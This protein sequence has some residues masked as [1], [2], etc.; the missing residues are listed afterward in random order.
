MVTRLQAEL[1]TASITAA[2]G[3]AVMVGATEFGIG[4]VK[5]GP[6]PGTFP[7][8]MGLLV[9][10]ASIGTAI[11]TVL[12]PVL[13][14][15]TFLD[16]RQL[17][18]VAAFVLPMVAF[19]VAAKLLGLYVATALYLFGSMLVQGGYG[20]W[21]SAAVALAAPVVLYLVLEKAFKVYLLKGPI[22]SMLGF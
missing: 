4:W 14:G 12:S 15:E 5:S 8:Y 10:V 6:E 18:T 17:R 16:G 11:Q 20:V 13:R 22:E 3:L 9:T 7:F 1:A 2:F 21:R 19:V